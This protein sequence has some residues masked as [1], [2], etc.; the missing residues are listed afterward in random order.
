MDVLLDACQRRSLRAGLAGPI[1]FERMLADL[2]EMFRSTQDG[3][4]H[5]LHVALMDVFNPAAD[6]TDEVMMLRDIREFVM[7]M[8]M[9]K[10]DRMDDAFDLKG[11]EGAVN[12]CLVDIRPD[13]VKDLLGRKRSPRL[14]K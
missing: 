8:I 1:E 2:G 4:L 3:G 13:F 12:G 5:L 10:V 7:G 6:Q 11:S 14:L 9:A